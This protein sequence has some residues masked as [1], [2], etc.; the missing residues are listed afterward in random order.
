[1][2][3]SIGSRNWCRATKKEQGISALQQIRFQGIRI[4]NGF[5][6]RY[7]QSQILSR[8][9]PQGTPLETFAVVSNPA[10]NNS[11]DDPAIFDSL[12]F[13]IDTPLVFVIDSHLSF[14]EFSIGSQ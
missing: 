11:F 7:Y 6:I 10:A 14:V 12:L 3:V 13:E 5:L 2:P 1:M 4:R 9:F 8:D